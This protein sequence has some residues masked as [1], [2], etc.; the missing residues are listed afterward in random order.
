MRLTNI[1]PMLTALP[2]STSEFDAAISFGARAI[3]WHLSSKYISTTYL[4]HH[5]VNCG[6]RPWGWGEVC[7]S[8][9]GLVSAGFQGVTLLTEETTLG[10]G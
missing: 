4:M 3:T 7:F 1:W 8:P 9:Y 5:S 10:L 6:W 2:I